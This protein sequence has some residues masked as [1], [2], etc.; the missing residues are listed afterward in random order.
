MKKKRLK[1]K[2]IVVLSCFKFCWDSFLIL[3]KTPSFSPHCCWNYYLLLYILLREKKS[4]W[5]N[6]ISFQAT[7]ICWFYDARCWKKKKDFCSALLLSS[8][9]S[10]FCVTTQKQTNKQT[11]TT[12][13]RKRKKTVFKTAIV[14]AVKKIMKI[15]KID[16]NLLTRKKWKQKQTKQEQEKTK[17]TTRVSPLFSSSSNLAMMMNASKKTVIIITDIIIPK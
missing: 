5:G 17:Q 1:Q 6:H 8:P 7:P 14:I 3:W 9:V 13:L 2:K 15:R 10:K 16:W 11:K 12:M 4:G